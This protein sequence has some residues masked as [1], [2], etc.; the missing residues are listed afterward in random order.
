MKSISSRTLSCHNG[1]EQKLHPA[2]LFAD[3]SITEVGAPTMH[4]ESFNRQ[5]QNGTILGAKGLFTAQ[6]IARNYDYGKR[7][8]NLP[9]TVDLFVPAHGATGCGHQLKLILLTAGF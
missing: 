5:S 4:L 3:F 2:L 6:E 8:G 7:L 1:Q 9:G